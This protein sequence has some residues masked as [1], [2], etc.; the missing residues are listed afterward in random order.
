MTAFTTQETGQ[1]WRPQR[2]EDPVRLYFAG[3]EGDT[4]EL[5]GVRVCGLPLELN[6]V[7]VTDW[8]DPDDLAGAAVAVIQVDSATPASVKRFQKLAKSTETPLIV[9][10]YDPPLALVRSLLRSGAVDVLPLPL[11]IVELETSIRQIQDQRGSASTDAVRAGQT[12]NIVT[13][14]KAAGGVGATTLVAQLAARFAANEAEHGREACLLD[15]DLQFGDAAFQ[16]GV[17]AGLSVADLLAAGTRLDGSLIRATSVRHESGLHVISAPREL[18]PV[19]GHSSDDFIHIADATAREFGTAFVE[20]PTN[21]TN[22]SVSLI[23]R[24]DL[25]LLVSELTVTSLNRARRQLELLRSEG[26]GDLNIRVVINRFDKSQLRTIRESDV[27][28]ALG[29]E[30]S[31]TIA[32]DPAIMRT[33]SDRGVTID[34]VKRKSAV[35]KDIDMLDAGIAATLGLER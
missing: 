13:V 19:E 12:S 29:Y 7:P 27:R 20:L 4:G 1:T 24:S 34:Q 8:I 14:L 22:W 26:L 9:A 11:D 6:L 17:Q 15:L 2:R 35:G 23:A 16:L 32:N 30:I 31:D 3:A 10:A 21:W 28:E 25:V 5:A 18:M 33:A